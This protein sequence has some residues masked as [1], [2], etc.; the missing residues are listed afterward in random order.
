M[1]ALKTSI[2]LLALLFGGM[3]PAMVGPADASDVKPWRFNRPSQE[4]PFARSERSQ[5]VWAAGTCWS[6]CG[7][8]CAWGQ[9][10]CLQRDSQGQCLKL[11]D[12]CDRYCQRNCRSAG[13]PLL[14]IELWWD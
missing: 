10:G 3:M 9:S 5:A 12:K 11:T 7:A 13:G 14:P 4:L 6:E 8:Y 2:V 1:R